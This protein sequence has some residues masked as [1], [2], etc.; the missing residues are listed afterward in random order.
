MNDFVAVTKEYYENTI[1]P[2]SKKIFED[3]KAFFFMEEPKKAEYSTQIANDGKIE[4]VIPIIGELGAS[5]Y[6]GTKYTDIQENIQ[7][8]DNDPD[9]DRIILNIDSPGGM[10]KGVEDVARVTKA[11]EKEIIAR[12]GYL[13]T[14]AAYW[15]ASQADKI[16]STSK[17][18][19]FGSIG[20][21]I[22]YYDWKEYLEKEGIKEVVITST[23]A[24]KKYL[25]PATKEGEV[26]VVKR[27]DN[28]HS[29][30]VEAVASGRNTTVENINLNYGKGGVLTAEEALQVGMID[31]ITISEETNMAKN[32]TEEE[33]G[34]AVKDATEKAYKKGTDEESARISG[35]LKY[36]GKAKNETVTANIKEGKTVAEC[37]DVYIEEATAKSILDSKIKASKD[38]E[39]IVTGD[40]KIEALTGEEDKKEISKAVMDDV[41]AEFGM[42]V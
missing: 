9:V 38:D 8:A 25:D 12:V 3:P 41:M 31:A 15:L 19:T 20:V 18:A 7:S 14:S 27:L 35:H 32:Y 10:V 36:L 21:I 22:S 40:E 13:A 26:E 16:E 17:I 23:D 33:F 4:A 11:T 29:V 42:E 5:R 37:A 28:I 30:F 34:A 1:L 24:P 2:R 39:T 6:W